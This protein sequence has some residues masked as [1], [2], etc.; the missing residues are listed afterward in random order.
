MDLYPNLRCALNT[1]FVMTLCVSSAVVAEDIIPGEP[2]TSR[3]I[4]VVNPDRLSAEFPAERIHLGQ[5]YKPTIARLP[6]GE[7]IVMSFFWEGGAHRPGGTY[8][9]YSTIWRSLDDGRTWSAGERASRSPEEDF[10]GREHW[11]TAIDDGTQHGLLFS[12]CQIALWDTSSPL[13]GTPNPKNEAPSYVSRSTDGGRTWKQ[14]RIGPDGFDGAFTRTNRNIVRMDDGRLMFGV[15]NWTG[16]PGLINYLWTSE[17]EGLTWQQSEQLSFGTY[18]NY[19]GEEQPFENGGPFIDETWFDI[20]QAGELVAYIRLNWTSPLFPIDE[21]PTSGGDQADR[22]ITATSTDGGL[23]WGDFKDCGNYGQM[24]ARVTRL[25]DDRLLLTITQ[26]DYYEGLT[27]HLGLRALVSNDDGKTWNFEKDL[28]ILDENTPLGWR[29]G[30]G[31]GTTLQLPD[32]SL[33]SCYSFHN[34]ATG[35]AVYQTEIVRWNLIDAK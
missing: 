24:Y 16:A 9:E 12:T 29:Q 23:T 30:G 15:A 13:F 33:I 26:R 32:G 25:N 10:I 4:R 8:H 34:E 3:P 31:F 22:T 27:E 7:L 11:L 20:N 21:T 5:G 14:E 2:D 6:S 17:D 19:K 28:I 1:A 18:T 35:Q